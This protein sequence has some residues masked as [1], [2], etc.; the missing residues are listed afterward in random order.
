MN[1]LIVDDEELMIRALGRHLKF[2]ACQVYTATGIE[3]AKRMLS[4]RFISLL[5]TDMDLGRG[6]EHGRAL[7]QWTAEHSPMTRRVLMSGSIFTRSCAPEAHC[8]LHKPFPFEHLK[9][10]LFPDEAA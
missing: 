6:P 2:E 9:P 10:L 4:D 1:I 5:L 8:I 7:L 3:Q